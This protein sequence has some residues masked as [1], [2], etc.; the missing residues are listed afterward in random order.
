MLLLQEGRTYGRRLP[1]GTRRVVE[2]EG[3]P[4]KVYLYHDQSATKE[5]RES[6]TKMVMEDKNGKDF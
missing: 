4:S 5:Q 6:F 1:I 3:R 2:E